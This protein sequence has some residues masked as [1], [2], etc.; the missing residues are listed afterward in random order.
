MTRAADSRAWGGRSGGSIGGMA[1]GWRTTLSFAV[2]EAG[3]RPSDQSGG[4]QFDIASC[5][6][7]FSLIW[8]AE[9]A[10]WRSP[11]TK[12]MCANPHRGF[13]QPTEELK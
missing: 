9:N 5:S 6:A 3:P 11:Q 7:C 10:L 13:V 2:S 4:T 1:S 12:Q 8:W